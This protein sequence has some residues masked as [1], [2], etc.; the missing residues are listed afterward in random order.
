MPQGVELAVGVAAEYVADTGRLAV[1]RVLRNL[2]R[3]I[4]AARIDHPALVLAVAQTLGGVE[5]VQTR[6]LERLSRRLLD[7][8]VA[9][10]AVE[11]AL[12]RQQLLAELCELAV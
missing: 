5:Q 7:N 8:A 10:D 1:H 12:L 2:R 9:L 6:C 3:R 11:A 4:D